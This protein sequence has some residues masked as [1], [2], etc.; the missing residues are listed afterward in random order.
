MFYYTAEN[1]PTWKDIE[2]YSLKLPI[3][4]Y[5]YSDNPKNLEKITPNPI[6]RNMIG[7]WYEVKKDLKEVSTLSRFSPIWG[8]NYFVQGRTVGGFK[9]WADRGVGQLKDIFGDHDESLL[10]FEELV[11]KY[12]IPRKHI[13]KYLQLRSFIGA[14]QKQSMLIPP[15]SLLEKVLI[16]NPFEKG[17][18]SES[19][20]VDLQEE[21][22]LEQWSSACKVAQTQMAN[23]HLKLLQYNWLMRVYIT[24]E[25]T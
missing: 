22:T 18:I 16:K 24:P 17:I 1:S 11:I 25:K 12:N 3:P 8:N 5:I 23:T 4:T 20:N 14:N 6:V 9:I 21:L 19:W 13:F 2:S 7:V 10:T 15:L